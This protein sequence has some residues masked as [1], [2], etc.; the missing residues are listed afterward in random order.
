[1]CR[2]L[3]VFWD[4]KEVFTLQNGYHGTHFKAT[5]GGIQGELIS[6]TL[7]NLIVKNLVWNWPE[8]TVEDQLVAQKGLGLTTGR[9][10]GLF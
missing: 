4:Q 1:M 10:I 8:M 5:R 3:A 7:F 6:T 2:L 9:C